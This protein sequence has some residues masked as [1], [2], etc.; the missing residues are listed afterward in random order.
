MK[1]KE[2]SSEGLKCHAL[3]EQD[4]PQVVIHYLQKTVAKEDGLSKTITVLRQ[5][6]EVE[7]KVKKFETAQK[8]KFD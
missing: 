2:K 5:K 3:T 4:V 7:E 1:K 8:A 6:K